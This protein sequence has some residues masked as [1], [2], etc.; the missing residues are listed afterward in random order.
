M[1]KTAES[2]RADLK[3][4]F[5]ESFGTAM[6]PVKNLS[7]SVQQELD[8]DWKLR[9][10]LAKLRGMFPGAK[11]KEQVAKERESG[12]EEDRVKKNL[13]DF[14]KYAHDE[15][16]KSARRPRPQKLG[17]TGGPHGG[18]ASSATIKHGKGST[19]GGGSS[20]GGGGS[21]KHHPFKR[22]PNLGVGPGTPPGFPEVR[23][24]VHHDQK[25]CWHCSCGNIYSKG[26]IC[27]GTGATKDCPKGHRKRVHIKHAYRQAYNDMYHAWRR[28]QGGQVT[29]RIADRGR[30]AG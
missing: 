27:I 12:G 8:E 21:G 15:G 10:K 28:K 17:F 9:E 5:G 4:I 11:K 13:S 16:E 25:K 22:S 1:A 18:S 14:Y 26:C 2:L 6:K 3:S 20:G 19:G 7:E 29:Q 30:K 24:K 23:G